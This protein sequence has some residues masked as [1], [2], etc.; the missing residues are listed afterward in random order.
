MVVEAV[1]RFTGLV[2][3]PSLEGGGGVPPPPPPPQEASRETLKIKVSNFVQID[4]VRMVF[5]L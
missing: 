1:P 3:E 2:I 4:F 5:S